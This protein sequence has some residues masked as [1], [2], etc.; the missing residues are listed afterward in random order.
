M[1]T[2]LITKTEHERILARIDAL[3]PGEG[4]VYR[5]TLDDLFQQFNSQLKA[6]FETIK[7]YREVPYMVN[8]RQP[9]ANKKKYVR[10]RMR[11]G[12]RED[13]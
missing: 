12:K 11:P 8:K 6:V 2:E 3:P 1:A 10:A 13:R 7:A 5:R 4:H 9:P